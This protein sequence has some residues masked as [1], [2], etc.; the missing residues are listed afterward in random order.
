MKTRGRD[1]MVPISLMIFC[2]IYW[3]TSSS[4]QP[5]PVVVPLSADGIQRIE[6]T[7]DSYSFKP[8]HLIVKASIPVE[9][10]LKNVA[11][12]T[13]HNFVL[14]SPEAGLDIKQEIAAGET[15]TVR[16]TPVRVGEFK[17]LCSK[18]LLF[19]ESHADRGMVGTLEVRQSG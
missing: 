3:A 7:V 8:S 18:K 9:L 1:S 4:A 12:I 10:T 19:F 6:I 16:F 2:F 15:A 13:P 5:Q 14:S 11:R 17:F